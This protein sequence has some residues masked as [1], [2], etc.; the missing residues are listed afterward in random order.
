MFKNRVHLFKGEER[1]N[2]S[3]CDQ[4]IQVGEKYPVTEGRLGYGG[5][6]KKND[7]MRRSEVRWIPPNEQMV[8]NLI[9]YYVNRANRNSFGIDAFWLYEIQFTTYNAEYEGH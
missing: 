6:R 3:L 1:P 8:A 7:E 4:I 9:W 5:E 2:Q